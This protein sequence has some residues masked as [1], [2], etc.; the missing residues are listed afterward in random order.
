MCAT[1]SSSKKSL[2]KKVGVISLITTIS[3]IL[4][5]I[6]EIIRATFLGTSFYNDAFTLAFSLPNLFRRL[7]AEGVMINAFIPVFC[8]VKKEEGEASALN[9]A[10]SFFWMATIVLVF[11]SILFIILSPWLVQYIFAPGFEGDSLTLTIFLTRF[12]F[13]YI[14]FIS[15][16]AIGQG[17]LNSFS[18]FWV[19][20]ITP[21]LLNIS[22]IGSAIWF[23]PRLA[24]P[25]LGFAIGVIIGGMI[26]LGF[27][28]PFLRKKGFRLLKGINFKNP[29]L[30]ETFKLIIP[31]IFGVGIYQINIIVSNLI[32]T[33]VGEGAISSLNFSNRLLELFLGIFVISIVTV[34]LPK[35]SVLFLEKQFDQITTDLRFALRITTFV[36]LPIIAGTYLLAEDIVSLVYKRGL[37]DQQSVILTAGALKYHI[38][39]LVF[40]SWNRLLTTG[41]QAAK[42]LK[43]MVQVS[44]V[45]MVVNI[46]MALWLSVEMK[47]LGI[48]LA[49]SISQA[50][51]TAL[52]LYFI[53]EFGVGKI[54]SWPMTKQ[55]FKIVICC[56]IM[57]AGV[58]YCK[59]LMVNW[60][61]WPLGLTLVI[62]IFIG[63][64]CFTIPA[65]ILKSSELMELILIFT[66]RKKQVRKV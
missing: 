30:L 45:I 36:S 60:V 63:I 20:A 27:H 61:E 46:V 9:Y 47:H 50:T 12:M 44:F 6:R 22:I 38:L 8:K 26:Q 11:F 33:T 4:G 42:Y 28:Y 51:Q 31:T 53:H 18:Q 1:G 58:Y 23:A 49:N 57:I 25:T 13:L 64:L 5:L 48:A 37:F 56:L 66:K 2:F 65:Y 24:N 7:T 52:L 15:L 40:I 59:K 62:N 21:V 55:I 43:R 10:T 34:I 16:A 3:R 41:Y 19:S 29:H 32:A 54:I 17:V 39:G 35:F 14:V